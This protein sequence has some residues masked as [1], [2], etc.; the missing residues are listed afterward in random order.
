MSESVRYAPGWPGIAP[1]WTS[2]A[3]TGLGTS[4][5]PSSRVWFTLSHG[6]LNEVY[7]PRVDQ[8]CLRD[9]GLIVT[10][11]RG[12]FS[13]EKRDA[14]SV[15]TWREAG[16]PAFRLLNTCRS[17]QYRIEKEIGTGPRRDVVLQQIRSSRCWIDFDYRVRVLAHRNGNHGSETRR[18][19]GTTRDPM[20][21]RAEWN[22]ARGGLC[23][24][25]LRGTAGFVGASDGWQTC[26]ASPAR[27]ELRPSANG[28]RGLAGE[29]D[30]GESDGRLVIALASAIRC[31]GGHAERG[32]PLDG[33]AKACDTYVHEWQTWQRSLDACSH[34]DCAD[35]PAR[36]SAAVLR[37]HEEKQF[38]GAIIAS[39]SIPWGAEK[40]DADL[41]GYHLVWPRDL[42]E[43]AGGLLAAGARANALRVLEY[44]RV[45]QDAEAPGAEHGVYGAFLARHPLD[46][47][48]LPSCLDSS[49]GGDSR[50]HR[51]DFRAMV[52]A[53]PA[54]SLLPSGQSRHDRGKRPGLAPYDGVESP[55]VVPPIWRAHGEASVAVYLRETA[56]AWNDSIEECLYVRDTE[57]ARRAGVDGYYVRIAPPERA[58]G[59][60]PQGGF[61]PIKNR[62]WPHANEPAYEII[63][64]DALALV[65]FGLRSPE[66]PR[67]QNT[68]RAIDTLLEV[69]TPCGPIWHRY[70]G[71]R[72]GE[73]QDGTAFDVTGIGRAW[74]LLTGERAHYEIAAGHIDEA[75]APPDA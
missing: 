5:C 10:D 59:P 57:L 24:R 7:Y 44:L 39:L 69:E 19:L 28:K 27:V 11:G 15:T 42:V 58:D 38:P 54:T 18:A 25:W 32:E 50:R 45:T 17:G 9:L 64:P 41:G 56:D 73:H 6:I 2:S 33:F 52:R 61:V 55:H 1:R 12:F 36:I 23:A 63:S 3:K 62:S 51:S 14:T 47:T 48:A 70:N 21:L 67:I 35:Q 74:P 60:S 71:D 68:L 4:L 72:Y 22:R 37:C 43:T 13:E 66:D 34:G 46:E 20:L 31:G 8:A 75:A 30:S 26:T 29:V 16:V 65:R 53:L 40:G 49:N